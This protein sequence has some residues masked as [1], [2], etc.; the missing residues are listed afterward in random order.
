MRQAPSRSVAQTCQMVEAK[1]AQ[2]GAGKDDEQRESTRSAEEPQARDVPDDREQL[3]RAVVAKSQ[4]QADH[5]D[6]DEEAHFSAASESDGEG[7]QREWSDAHVECGF[8]LEPERPPLT[9]GT[10][11][12]KRQQRRY[13][14]VPA[15]AKSEADA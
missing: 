5:G 10:A 8:P 11:K 4:E 6:G 1:A 7:C 3:E 12:E 15:I 2:H 14:I 9:I 13:Q